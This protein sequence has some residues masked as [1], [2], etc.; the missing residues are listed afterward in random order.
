M[1]RQQLMESW[2]RTRPVKRSV[3]CM[4]KSVCRVCELSFIV[5]QCDLKFW[6]TDRF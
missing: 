4:E 1:A 5:D 2:I 3:E 6:I